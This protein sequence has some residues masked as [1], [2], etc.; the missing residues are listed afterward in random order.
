MDNILEDTNTSK[1]ESDS[2]ELFSKFS[3]SQLE[4]SMSKILERYQ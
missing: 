3:R 2:E 4:E 1:S